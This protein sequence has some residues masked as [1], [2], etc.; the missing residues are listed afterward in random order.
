MARVTMTQCAGGGHITLTVEERGGSQHVI[1]TDRETLLGS[2]DVSVDR[3]EQLLRE[4]KAT[5]LQAGAVTF[6]DAKVAV[7][8]KEFSD[9]TRE[10]G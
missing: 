6:E 7:D 9:D 1:Q 10:R 5:I 8:A 4:T 2:P 3:D